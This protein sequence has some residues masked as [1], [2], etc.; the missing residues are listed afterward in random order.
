[1]HRRSYMF[2]TLAQ[3]F[4]Q[5]LMVAAYPPKQAS[6]DRHQTLLHWTRSERVA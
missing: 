6:R 5:L 2:L 3:L 4:K 1:M